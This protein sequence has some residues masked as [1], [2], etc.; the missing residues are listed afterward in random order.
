[1]NLNLFAVD[2]GVGDVEWLDARPKKGLV[3][4]LH[5]HISVPPVS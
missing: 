3:A 5:R 2:V 1:M 4:Y